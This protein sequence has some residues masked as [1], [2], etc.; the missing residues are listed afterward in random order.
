[1][2][3]AIGCASKQ[4]IG[5]SSP[6]SLHNIRPPSNIDELS[7]AEGLMPQFVRRRSAPATH[8]VVTDE[9]DAEMYDTGDMDGTSMK[10]L[11]APIK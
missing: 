6:L 2:Q 7:G 11:A 9:I 4:I 5:G 1:M 8:Q 3:P 10:S